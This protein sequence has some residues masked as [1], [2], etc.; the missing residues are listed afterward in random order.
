M[1]AS[2]NFENMVSRKTKLIN[3]ILQS[4]PLYAESWNTW[5]TSRF[6]ICTNK[7]D[8]YTLE[9]YLK[10]IDKPTHQYINYICQRCTMTFRAL[11]RW[12]CSSWIKSS[13][14][15]DVICFNIFNFNLRFWLSIWIFSKYIKKN[16]FFNANTMELYI[17]C[18]EICFIFDFCFRVP[19]MYILSTFMSK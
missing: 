15:E 16:L 14:M 12:I 18:I 17:D 8:Y 13:W 9:I 2:L 6:D 11:F 4:S 3:E 7:V 5:N 10:I 1:S 19:L